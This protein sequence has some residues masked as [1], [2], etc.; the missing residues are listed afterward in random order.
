MKKV[1]ASINELLIN[2][3][4]NSQV[5]GSD[6]ALQT[7]DVRGDKNDHHH[8]SGNAISFTEST[9]K[10]GL[11]AYFFKSS[12]FVIQLKTKMVLY[13]ICTPPCISVTM[14]SPI[15]VV[16]AVSKP[17]AFLAARI[18]TGPGF[19]TTNA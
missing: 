7:V 11:N 2:F 3:Y 19:P 15:T 12:T 4:Q 14:V 6:L 10:S 5:F 1:K 8:E 16:S 13:P 17:S 18:I 9:T